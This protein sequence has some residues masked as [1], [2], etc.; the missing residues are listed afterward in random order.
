MLDDIIPS[1]QPGFV[2]DMIFFA[3]SVDALVELIWGCSKELLVV[4]K[5]V[6]FE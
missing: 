2:L 6:S 4:S 3:K 1:I 5:V